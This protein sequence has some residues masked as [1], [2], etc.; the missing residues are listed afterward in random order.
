[1]KIAFDSWVLSRR[2]ANHGT[3]VYARNLLAQFQELMRCRPGLEL[4]TFARP[5]AP[6][7]EQ[8]AEAGPGVELVKTQWLGRDRL[9]RLAGANLAAARAGADLMFSPAPTTLPL[10]KVPV[11][12]TIHD[13]TP[14]LMPSNSA[15]VAFMLRSLVKAAAKLSQSIITVSECSKKDVVET[16]GVPAEKI[17][18]VYNGYDRKAFNTAPADPEEL[19]ALRDRSGTRRPY[20]FHHSVIQPRK[21]LIR[22]MQ[23]HRQLLEKRADL[24]LDLVLAGPLGWQYEDIVASAKASQHE[25]GQ[26]LLPGAMPAEE[27]ATLIKGASLV[28]IPSLYEG[29]CMPMIESMACGAPV[30]AAGTSCLPEV[31]GNALLYFDPTSP[32]EMSEKMLMVLQDNDLAQRL[33][34]AGVQ[35]AQE[36]SWEKCAAETLKVLEGAC[37]RKHK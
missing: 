25:R 34:Q 37:A 14:M 32:D 12:V 2:F 21:N 15:R 27:L 1:M 19:R 13:A 6:D 7:R 35:R 17:S 30:I 22:L 4:C 8:L 10:G 3:H 9:W 24:E 11:V 28:V 29:F 36:F 5:E 16:C 33:K 23:A 18:V 20:V 26:V 31:S